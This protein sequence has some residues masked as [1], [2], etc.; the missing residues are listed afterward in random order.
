MSIRLP[1]L[2]HISARHASTPSPAGRRW[3]EAPDE[4][5]MPCSSFYARRTLTPTPLP[6]GEGLRPL[7]YSAN[8]VRLCP[9]CDRSSA[10]PHRWQT[11]TGSHRPSPG[12]SSA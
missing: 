9:T 7:R 2:R 1:D 11:G 10:G 12:S 5:S 6:V 8:Q 3:R 4:G